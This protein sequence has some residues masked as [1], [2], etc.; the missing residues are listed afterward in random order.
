VQTPPQ[1]VELLAHVGAPCM[2]TPFNHS[3]TVVALHNG[4][5]YR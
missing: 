2:T 1:H 4:L 5:A 3:L